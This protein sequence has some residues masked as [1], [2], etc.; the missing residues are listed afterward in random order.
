[1]I[2]GNNPDRNISAQYFQEELALADGVDLKHRD[3]LKGGFFEDEQ[4]YFEMSR[5]AF[6]IT[7]FFT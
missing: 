6:D 5:V 7:L 2:S 4:N 1:V 3:L